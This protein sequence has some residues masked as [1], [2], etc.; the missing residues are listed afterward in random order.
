MHINRANHLKKCKK[1]GDEI[2]SRA[3]YDF[4]YCSCKSIA[5][6]TGNNDIGIWCPYRLI[7]NPDDFDGE[8]IIDLNVT[9]Y[10]LYDDWNLNINKYGVIKN[11]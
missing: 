6:D 8:R 1:C 4:R 5:V 2:Y 11:E 3:H 7:G 9:E 10:D